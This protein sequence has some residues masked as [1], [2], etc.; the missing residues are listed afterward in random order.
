MAETG[1]TYVGT[2]VDDTRIGTQVWNNPTDIEAA[3][4]EAWAGSFSSTTHYL[5]GHN[6][7]FSIP[8][9]STIDGIECRMRAHSQHTNRAITTLKIVKSDNSIGSENKGPGAPNLFTTYDVYTFGSSSDLWS[10]TWTPA[11]INDADFGFVWS[12]SLTRG[13]AD[14]FQINVHYTEGAGGAGARRNLLLGVG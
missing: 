5:K 10:E 7:G 14:Y 4:G 6:L 3:G 9:G 11:D 12:Q 13:Y 2:G 8:E 1:F